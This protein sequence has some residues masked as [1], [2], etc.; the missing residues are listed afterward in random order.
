MALDANVLRPFVS[1]KFTWKN[2]R[3]AFL[4]CLRALPSVCR[5]TRYLRTSCILLENA[6]CGSSSSG[7]HIPPQKTG[8]IPSTPSNQGPAPSFGPVLHRGV[9]VR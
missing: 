8:L 6:E 4:C 2:A 1:C 9:E 3:S 7:L 5:L